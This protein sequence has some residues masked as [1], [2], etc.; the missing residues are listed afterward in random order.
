LGKRFIATKIHEGIYPP[1]PD[2]PELPNGGFNVV[3][4]AGP[5]TTTDNILNEPLAD[6][7]SYLEKGTPPDLCI[8]LGPFVD[9]KHPLLEKGDIGIAYE[10]LFSELLQPLITAATRS[11]MQL[12]VVPSARDLHHSFVYPQPPYNVTL[13]GT[14]ALTS[15]V[16]FVSDPC[17]LDIDGVVI[18]LT[19]TDILFHLG[20]EEISSAQQHQSTDRISRLVQHVLTQQTYYPLYPPHPDVPL[21]LEHFDIYCR[22]PV[23]P[24]ILVLPS[25]LRCFIKD[26]GPTVCVNPG[27]MAKGQVGGTFTR[28]NVSALRGTNDNHSI[29]SSVQAEIIRI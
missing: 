20:A 28:L 25:D 1:S 14:E 26:V 7:V 2:N 15:Y 17:T 12:I 27:R 13:A 21:D 8:V 6:L 3:I 19:S 23:A 4:A 10:E 18:G 9:A 24:H 11:R 16:H 5:F 29:I 22:L